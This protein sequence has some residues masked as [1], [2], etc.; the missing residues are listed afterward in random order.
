LK[1]IFTCLILLLLCA[2]S[3]I[4]AQCSFTAT[5]ITT[6]SRCKGSG[7]ITINSTPAAAY[8]YQITA[9]PSVGDPTS[10][11]IFSTLPA[12]NYIIKVTLGGCSI[13]IAATVKGNYIEPGLLTGVVKKI[14]CPAGTGC[15]TANQPVN[16]RL[17][18]SYALVSGPVT[19]PDQ[20][21]TQFCDL[22]AGTYTL[23]A[24]DSCGV[25]RSTNYTIVYDTGTFVAFTYGYDLRHANCTDLIICPLKG[26]TGTTSHS[27][28][29]IWYIKPN[30][31]T[32]KYNNLIDPYP[33]D[34]LIGESHTYGVWTMLGFDSCGR[35]VT[36]TF[37]HSPPGLSLDYKGT[38]CGGFE[39]RIGNAWKYGVPV[40]YT[41]RRC[42]DNSIVYNV[43][44]TPPTTF[45]S[46][47][48]L[49]QHDSCYIFEHYNNCGD[50][51]RT[52]YTVPPKPVFKINAC[53][54]TAC[55][56]AGKGSITVY[57]NYL[58]GTSPVTYK[59]IAGPEGVGMTAVQL[60]FASYIYLR[61]LAMG[62]YQ[63]EGT[64]ACG[65][66]DTVTVTLNKPLQ[67]SITITKTPNC[68]GGA[69][70]HIKVVSTFK[71]CSFA[72]TLAGNIIRVD[73]TSPSYFPVNINTVNPT[74][75]TPGVWEADYYNVLPG[76]LLLQTYATND[77]CAWDT[78]INISS[79]TA[80]VLSNVTGYFCNTTG[81]GT[82][83]YILNGGV[84]AFQ[85]R[86]R[87][88]GAA[89]WS[90]WQSNAVFT[91]ISA[92]VYELNTI[93]AC[94]NG[95]ITSFSFKPWVKSAITFN[96]ACPTIG[97]P[98]VL[99]SNPNIPGVNYQ[100]LL[101]GV[102]IGTDPQLTIPNFQSTN[103]GIYK[104]VQTFPGG[105]CSDSSSRWV[106]N[107]SILP[108]QFDKLS[109][110]LFA[111]T[112]LLK[113]NTLQEQDGLF[114]EIEKSSDGINF[115]K[116]GSIN[117]FNL[118]NGSSYKFTDANPGSTNF[119]RIKYKVAEGVTS[120]SNIIQVI[121]T[122]LQ[123]TN[124]TVNP[125]PFTSHL[126]VQIQSQFKET[127]TVKIIDLAGNTLFIKN[128]AI[129]KGANNIILEAPI[130]T[131]PSGTYIIEIAG[132]RERFTKKI[133]KL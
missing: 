25:V 122:V 105:N 48:F 39:L 28:I 64:D 50:T 63:V 77:G 85:Y 111:N 119:Y 110:S 32:I 106:L 54:G 13:N 70:L 75:I 95:S 71:Q 26:F 10:L 51:I 108:V 109:G 66:K 100:W 1:N 132:I 94:P 116:I 46:Q 22:P 121:N 47:Y 9:G 68:S 118:F 76:N 52:R 6:E 115:S 92:G 8:T 12:G 59:I 112:V 72:S 3:K 56:V 84:P 129:N 67:R 57:Q 101:D 40:G 7:T 62:T 34:T 103:E 81:T 5:A 114:F 33:C 126:T 133:I 23:Q 60:Q 73:V 53:D 113:W 4:A 124:I 117:A 41:V 102:L 104:L 87:R 20:A 27:Q 16:G 36:S 55:S 30:G 21:S 107:C 131:M 11:N 45:F 69:N 43:N 44:Q 2:S 24:H 15:I 49:L 80:P 78:T 35:M 42:S 125:T 93:D 83:N 99:S 127:G 89:S 74:D 31:D 58:S 38:V 128:V 98:F 65:Q 17:P 18:Y 90:G 120:Y 61:D 86:I 14:A 19:R 96:N 82:I 37:T 91:G 88:Q 79:Y 97:Q 130:T 123:S 29:K